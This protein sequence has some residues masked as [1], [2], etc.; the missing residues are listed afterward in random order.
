MCASGGHMRGSRFLAFVS[1]NRFADILFHYQ[2]QL[3]ARRNIKS[4][5]SLFTIFRISA[6]LPMPRPAISMRSLQPNHFGGAKSI[7]KKWKLG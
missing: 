6:K 5:I 2:S 1:A 7:Q 3:S 4:K